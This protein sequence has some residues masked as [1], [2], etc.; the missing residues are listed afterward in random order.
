VV[1]IES[2]DQLNC[3]TIEELRTIAWEQQKIIVELR[4]VIQF[5][6]DELLKKDKEIARLTQRVAELERSNQLNSTNS[7]KPPSSDGFK[8]E[9]RVQSLRKKSGKKVGGQLGHTGYTLNQVEKPDN[10]ETLKVT[11]C[12]DCNLDLSKEPIYK[13][14]KRQVFDIPKIEKPIVTEYHCEVKLCPGCNRTVENS[15]GLQAP[16]QYGSRIIAATAYFHAYNLLPEERTVDVFS[17]LFGVNMSVGTIENL[18]R[19]LEEKIKPSVE[20]IELYLK[21]ADVK[22]ADESGIRVNGELQ[23]THVLSNDKASHY[24]LSDKRGDVPTEVQG[25]LVHD[26]FVSYEKRLP[27]ITHAFCN[28]HHLRELNA[29]HSVD[30]ERW[31]RSMARLL[32]LGNKKAEQN[33][34]GID[35]KWV[36]KYRALYDKIIEK[37][38]AYHATLKPLE[39]PSRGRIKRRPGHNLLLRLNSCADG[40][41]LF[42][43]DPDVPFTNNCSEQSLRMIKVKQKVSGCFRT[44]KGAQ[45]FLIIKSYIDTAQKLCFDIFDAL[46]Q[47]IQHNP[48]HFDFDTT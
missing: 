4:L 2:K 45:C 36:V 30:K 1:V 29:V 13:I 6:Q 22:G 18:I 19:Q 14:N 42:L 10:I 24:R 27:D 17:K 39:K 41:L 35:S 34:T 21:A 20:K 12:L 40:V 32:V 15:N 38:F 8:K 31:G 47:A 33:P 44:V 5:L 48:I 26:H 28:A 25:T 46:I 9:P 11:S 43:D 37:G 3:L 23:W 16:V 7:G